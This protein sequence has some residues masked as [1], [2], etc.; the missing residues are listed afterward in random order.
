MQVEGNE[1]G[2]VTY[3]APGKDMTEEQFID[4]LN[5]GNGGRQYRLAEYV[6][7]FLLARDIELQ[8]SQVNSE[9]FKK[10][11]DHQSKN[12]HGSIFFFSASS[13]VTRNNQFSQV[14][15]SRNA[16]GMTIKIPGAQLI[17]YYTQKMPRFPNTQK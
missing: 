10:T 12:S 1:D 2:A 11:V 17:G 13:S 9:I 5:G 4:S 3:V 16:N 8:F 15:T 14:T 6:T 7:S